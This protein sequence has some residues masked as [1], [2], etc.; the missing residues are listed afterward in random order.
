VVISLGAAVALIRYQRKVI[1]VIAVCAV[2]GLVYR[3]FV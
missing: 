1:H 3:L 2:L